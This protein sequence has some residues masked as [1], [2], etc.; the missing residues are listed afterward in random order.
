MKGES[1]R[2]LYLF[3]FQNLIPFQL[4]KVDWKIT[5]LLLLLF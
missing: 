2:K 4:D 3:L 5:L 1:E